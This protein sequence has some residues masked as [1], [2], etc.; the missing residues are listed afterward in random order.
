MEHAVIMAGGSGTRFWP[1]SRRLRPKQLLP[2]TGERTLLQQTAQRVRP[3][4][5]GERTWVVTNER[6]AGA[7]AEQL[8]DIPPTQILAE[9]CPRN[10]APCI[11]LAA[12]HLLNADPDA[13]MVVMPA[14]HAIAPGSEFRRNARAAAAF[15]FEN[16]DAF[17]L[18]GI[19]P[20][21]PATGFGYIERG[22]DAIA[23]FDI[24]RDIDPDGEHLVPLFPVRSFRE[25][26]DRAT[27]ED[28]LR[29]GT[30]FWNS[31]IFVWRAA[32]ILQALQTFEP[33]MAEHLQ[34]IAKHIGT[35]RYAT[36]LAE[37]FPLM[38]SISVDYAV[39]ERAANVAVIPATFQWDDLGSW[40][41]VARL[42][43]HDEQGNTV[44]GVHCGID[45]RNCIV[46]GEED[47]LIAT[48]GVSD[49][50][51]VQTPDATL[52]ARRND[53]Q[54]I[55]RIVAA[56]EKDEKLHRYL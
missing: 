12:I 36:A 24:K 23:R 7:M 48:A 1:A 11:G 15:L 46:H 41:A 29:R 16:P 14:D 22:D 17:V 39:L 30:F 43:G 37:H 51:I 18:F 31:G 28:Y 52:V 6:L 5:D 26:P 42:R 40:E 45:T 44:V 19:P 2:L 4:I 54:L 47:H 3:W 35:A 53:E 25:K 56:L 13:I 10:T 55:R 27:A 38:K 9:P 8:P 50:V 21:Y 49:L 32:A 20:T 34:A 33:E